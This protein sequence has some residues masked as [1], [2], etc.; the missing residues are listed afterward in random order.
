MDLQGSPF[1]FGEPVHNDSILHIT[2]RS[3]SRR[4]LQ[5]LPITRIIRIASFRFR[6]SQGPARTGWAAT[7]RFR[8]VR[9]HGII[10]LDLDHRC[11]HRHHFLNWRRAGN[12]PS[13][14]GCDQYVKNIFAAL[15]TSAVPAVPQGFSR[16]NQARYM[17][18]IASVTSST[19]WRMR[20]TTASGS[21]GDR[22][23]CMP[24]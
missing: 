17:P 18:P 16:N 21:G 24:R 22:I 12:F 7:V 5:E 19:V 11:D 1:P 10:T 14:M 3:S 4:G 20:L 8:F 23:K 15:G 9:F 2:S 6:R 13:I